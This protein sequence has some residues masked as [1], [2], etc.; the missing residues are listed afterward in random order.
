[1][2]DFLKMCAKTSHPHTCNFHPCTLNTHIEKIIQDKKKVCQTHKKSKH[3]YKLIKSKSKHK[4]IIP[5]PLGKKYILVKKRIGEH[6]I[7]KLEQT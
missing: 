1:M 4:N 6:N 2:L 3:S 7:N 5:N